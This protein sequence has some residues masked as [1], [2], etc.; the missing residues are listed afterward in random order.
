MRS[1]SRWFTAM[2][3][4]ALVGGLAW[5][6]VA[7][8]PDRGDRGRSG[9]RFGGGPG[10]P[11]GFGGPGGPGGPGG[12]ANNPAFELARLLRIDVVQKDLDLIDDQKTELAS[13]IQDRGP[14]GPGGPG[15]GPGGP[16]GGPG[17]RPGGFGDLSGEELRERMN[18]MREQMDARGKEI[19]A[20]LDE[21][22]LPYQMDRLKQIALQSRGVQAFGDP[23]VADAI[24]LTREQRDEIRTI[25]EKAGESMRERMQ[26]RF[27][28]GR[29]GGRR[30]GGRPDG[31]RP[32][33][34]RPDGERPERGPPPGGAGGP[35]GG[36][37]AMREQFAAARKE[38]ETAVMAVLTDEQKTKYNELIGAKI[39]LPEE[40]GVFGSFGGFGGGGFGGRFGG[41]GGGPPGG[42][43]GGGGPGGVRPRGRPAGDNN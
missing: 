25:Q 28:G 34:E 20:K 13:L 7:Q 35:G 37:E 3:A 31:D 4:V 38:T 21:V 33:G 39:E 5:Q 32:E 22:L 41:P 12:I 1:V 14:G 24:G 27:G 36:F 9:G 17:G 42:G 2:L 18:E 15:G 6:A 8:Q 29:D 40:G 23:E 11:G 10:G 19:M 43:P 26:A 16:G 30:P